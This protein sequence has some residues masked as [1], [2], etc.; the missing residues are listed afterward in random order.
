MDWCGE[1]VLLHL[2]CDHWPH[3]SHYIQLVFT[4]TVEE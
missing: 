2:K 3:I 4:H 1:R